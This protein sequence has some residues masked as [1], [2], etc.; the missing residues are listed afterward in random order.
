MTVSEQSSMAVV[1]HSGGQQFPCETELLRFLLNRLKV[2]G[3][4]QS[5]TFGGGEFD[6]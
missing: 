5:Q 2:H 4:R 3:G 6:V 1:F